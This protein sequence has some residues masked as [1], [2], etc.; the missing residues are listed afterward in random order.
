MATKKLRNED[1]LE[2]APKDVVDKVKEKYDSLE[3]NTE[4]GA[5]RKQKLQKNLD[6]IKELGA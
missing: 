1:F 6:K 2:K 4:Y 3:P 5:L